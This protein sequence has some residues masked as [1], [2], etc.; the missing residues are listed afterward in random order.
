MK[1]NIKTIIA[2]AVI[3]ICLLGCEPGGS[4]YQHTEDESE[5]NTEVEV[6]HFS[7]QQFKSLDMKIDT[8]PVRNMNSYVEANGRLEVPPQNEAAVTAIIGANIT[9]IRVI[10]GEK[11][12]KGKVLAYLS[13]PNLIRLQTDYVN[14][15]SQLRFLEK[16][17]ERQK[18]LYEENVG[19]GKEFQKT[20]ADFQSMKALVKG[21][22]AQL[23]LMGID[24]EKVQSS[25]IYDHVPVITPI[26]G[27]VRQVKVKTG[28]Y[29]E[30]Q[31][32]MFDIVN[33][34]HVHADLM[35]F[36]KD[37]HKVK[38]GQKVKFSIAS[39][40][41]KE[42][43]AIIFSVGKSFEQDPKAIHLHAEIENKQGLLI[44]GM[45]VRGRI[46]VDDKQCYALPE[47][48][49]V[50]EGDKSFIFVADEDNDHG[51]TEWVFK[52]IEVVEGEKDD[53]WVEIKPLAQFDGNMRVAWNN[54]YYLLA[55]M[56][57]GDAEHE[58]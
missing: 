39:M 56:K 31:T 2:M 19:S 20:Q 49:V 14:N 22:E 45:Y 29:V 15:W 21:Y 55:E 48:G 16:E 58:H 28:Q 23:K 46:L 40:P 11:V 37:M 53:G 27:Y 57:K 8:L 5:V 18:R 54:A 50:R 43:T 17:Y 34:D 6:V 33:N 10:E 35:V 24:L 12:T 52:P 25:D 26:D 3:S 30:P 44:P 32:E 51:E 42:L 1:K 41:D 9:S 13:H 7:P 4:S 36:E 38:E 47:S